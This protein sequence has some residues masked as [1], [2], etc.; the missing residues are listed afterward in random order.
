[1]HV[2]VSWHRDLARIKMTY[3]CGI[4]LNHWTTLE[5]KLFKLH[6]EDKVKLNKY[7]GNKDKHDCDYSLL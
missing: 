3:S 7:E 6:S 1:M 5:D 4:A 2:T